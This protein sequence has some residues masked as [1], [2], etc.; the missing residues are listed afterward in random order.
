MD[1]KLLEYG[2]EPCGCE[3]HPEEHHHLD[4]H[5][6]LPWKLFLAAFKHFYR[7]EEFGDHTD[8]RE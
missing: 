3:S 7:K 1:E 5:T 4:L 8:K 6:I 2:I